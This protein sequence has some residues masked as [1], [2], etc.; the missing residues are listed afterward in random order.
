VITTDFSTVFPSEQLD[1][2]LCPLCGRFQRLPQQLHFPPFAVVRCAHCQLWYLAP[3]LLESAML[4]AYANPEYFAGGG[5]HG[6]A[7]SQGSYVAQAEALQRTF[8]QFL[9][10]LQQRGLT[11]GSL[12]E[13]GA[14][15]G[16]LLQQA[17]PYFNQLSGTDFDAVAVENI[18]Q[19]GFQAFLGGIEALP[20]QARY[21]VIV[22][23]GVIEHI[24]QPVDFVNK[25]RKHLTA[26]GWLILATPQINGF[27]FWLQG[28]RWSSFKI[29]E[30]VTYYD[31]HT[32][33]RLYQQCGCLETRF[34]PY[35]AAYPLGLIG[36]K[37]GVRL[38]AFLTQYS[39]WLPATM[40][41]L[42]A[43]FSDAAD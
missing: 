37:L 26:S 41:A 42:A 15:Y 11:G 8:Q 7:H 32:L 16:Y 28:K 43:R 4:Q 12:L 24:Y 6:Y 30:H 19:Q 39:L 33:N 17:R 22:A 1:D 34:I 29:P 31:R 14:G 2:P 10:N 35:P 13:I 38:P 21:E 3:R 5:E 23:T 25:V 20:T 27:W 18:R 40:F 9:H 36:E